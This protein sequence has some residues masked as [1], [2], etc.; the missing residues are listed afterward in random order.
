MKSE[1]RTF[2]V[3]HFL[4]GRAMDFADDDSF[5]QRG[6]IDSTG[7]LELIGWLESRWNVKV[8]DDELLPENLDSVNRVAG[9]V[10]RKRRGMQQQADARAA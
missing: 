2:I 4:F 3:E 5:L 10:E 6:I 1:L 7:V 9:F 8:G